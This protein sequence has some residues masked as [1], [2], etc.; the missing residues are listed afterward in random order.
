MYCTLCHTINIQIIHIYSSIIHI[1]KY[2][3][4]DIIPSYKP[5]F[6]VFMIITFSTVSMIRNHN[7]FNSINFAY[8]FSSIFAYIYLMRFYFH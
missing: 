5:Y 4:S 2:D 8:Q 1:V 6:P 7:F 3:T